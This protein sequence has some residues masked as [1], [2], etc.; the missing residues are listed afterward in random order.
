MLSRRVL[1]VV[2]FLWVLV[3]LELGSQTQGG[4]LVL[5]II[6]FSVGNGDSPLLVLDDRS[7]SHKTMLSV[8]VDG[9]SRS[10][11]ATVVIPGIRAAGIEGLDYG[12]ATHK[13]PDH[14]AGLY[15]VL[16]AIPMT[17]R[18]SVYAR[19]KMAHNQGRRLA[20]SWN[21]IARRTR[22]GCFTTFKEQA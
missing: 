12:I 6:H 21:A 5:K 10:M 20:E 3:P 1:K 11:A 16:A 14:V 7:S 15:E 22:E 17:G 19:S 13:D 4:A 8:L 2:L 9:G 18:G